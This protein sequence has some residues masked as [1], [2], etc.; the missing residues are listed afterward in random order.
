MAVVVV[1]V[2]GVVVVV[3][4]MVVTMVAESICSLPHGARSII[5]GD[6]ADALSTLSCGTHTHRKGCISI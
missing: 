5:S 4:L 3:V 1:V 6:A 2:V